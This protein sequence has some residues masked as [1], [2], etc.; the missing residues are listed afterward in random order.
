MAESVLVALG[1]TTASSEN[2][3][4]RA[5][6]AALSESFPE[7][8]HHVLDMDLDLELDPATRQYSPR[9][10]D[11]EDLL[12]KVSAVLAEPL[13]VVLLSGRYALF[14]PVVAALSALKVF[15]DTDDDTRLI[16]LIRS[17]SPQTPDAL[18]GLL[19]DYVH[20]V[21]N[22]D[23]DYVKPTRARADLIIPHSN[24]VSLG[25]AII[26]DGLHRCLDN[27]MATASTVPGTARSFAVEQLDALSGRYFDAA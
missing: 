17:Q 15:V 1:G 19:E 18:S 22:E 20:H 16:S 27:N 26:V 23:R 9:D 8:T 24:D 21:R 3:V 13:T 2:G 25:V 11:F 7:F 4:L 5:L 6:R 12:S 10:F 14:D